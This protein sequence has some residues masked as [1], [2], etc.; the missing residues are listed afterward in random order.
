MTVVT[1]RRLAAAAVFPALALGVAACGSN[2]PDP[3]S[4]SDDNSQLSPE[5]VVL[6]SYEGLEGESYQMEMTMTVNGVDFM[7]ATSQVEG[8]S[9]RT[10]QDLYMSAILEAMGEEPPEDPET[11][12]MME[13]MFS[14]VHTEMILVDGT[15]Y[16]QLS[17]GALDTTEAF[18]EDAWFTFDLAEIADLDQVYQQFGGLDL[19]SQT[20][21]LLT[22]MTDV[23]ETGNGVYT[24][25]LNGQSELME[26]VLGA[27]GDPA[28]AAL[29]EGAEVVVT[30]DGDGLLNKLE[31]T[32]PET[33]G[34]TMHL[35]SE[36]VEIGDSYDI[37]APESDNLHSFE[38]LAGAMQ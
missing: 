32:F 8:E 9:S 34:M 36:V 20:E 16:M 12:E 28:A 13:A 5:Q 3:G 27:T 10:S 21:T 1:P 30:L 26:S 29:V 19:A 24:G 23:E 14:D 15:A 2:G 4:N 35:V 7:S 11:A 31:I 17:G 6:S 38:E 25:T 33:E 22:E 18:G 37:T